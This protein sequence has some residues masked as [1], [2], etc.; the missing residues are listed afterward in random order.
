M[1]RSIDG[2]TDVSPAASMAARST[3]TASRWRSV[4]SSQGPSG[5]AAGSPSA[6]TQA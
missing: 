6:S 4:H 1:A 5:M 2:G 3:L